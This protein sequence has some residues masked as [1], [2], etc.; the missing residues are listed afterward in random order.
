MRCKNC[1]SV[2][3]I[4]DNGQQSE[5]RHFIAF[6]YDIRPLVGMC[7]LGV[8]Y[9]WVFNIVIYVRYVLYVIIDLD[10]LKIAK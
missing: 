3:G 6:S 10:V 8:S 9:R 5:A 7:G 4:K 1:K 2:I